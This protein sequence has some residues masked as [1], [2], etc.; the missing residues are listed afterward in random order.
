M[1]SLLLPKP[2]VHALTSSPRRCDDRYGGDGDPGEYESYGV[3]AFGPAGPDVRSRGCGW[4][5]SNKRDA[6][7]TGWREASIAPREQEVTFITGPFSGEG[8]G[9]RRMEQWQG[10]PQPWHG[11]RPKQEPQ[12][13]VGASRMPDWVANDKK[14][15][16]R[17]PSLP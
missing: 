16:L 9:G 5:G 14:V 2:D 8:H 7:Y 6:H 11:L 1:R 15:G 13:A 4:S 3:G 10:L 17:V 12:G